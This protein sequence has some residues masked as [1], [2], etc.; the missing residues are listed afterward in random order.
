[1]SESD[2][3]CPIGSFFNHTLKLAIPV[4]ISFETFVETEVSCCVP[5]FPLILTAKC[6]S[7]DVESESGVGNFG[8]GGVG[9]IGKSESGFGNFG[10]GGVEVGVGYFTSNSATLVE[11]SFGFD[12]FLV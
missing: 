7:F 10:K 5:R 11:V 3:G 2:S 9:N 8:K 4:E 6:H 1:M 12:F